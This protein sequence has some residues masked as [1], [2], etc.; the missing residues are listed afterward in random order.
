[1]SENRNK[2]PDKKKVKP[3]KAKPNKNQNPGKVQSG[4]R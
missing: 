2:L 1:M 3:A 4:R